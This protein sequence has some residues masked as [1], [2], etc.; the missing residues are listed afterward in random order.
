MPNGINLWTVIIVEAWIWFV[1]SLLELSDFLQVV[2]GRIF[3][4]TGTNEIGGNRNGRNVAVC[5]PTELVTLMTRL[6]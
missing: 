6:D 4:L 3:L 1:S 2:R 5:H